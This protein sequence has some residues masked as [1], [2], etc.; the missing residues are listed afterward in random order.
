V[1]DNLNDQ[2][3]ERYDNVLSRYEC[4]RVIAMLP[5]IGQSRG[6][7]GARHLMAVTE[8]D[9]LASDRRL[10]H[11]AR[12]ELADEAIAA[13]RRVLHIEYADSLELNPGIR[14]ALT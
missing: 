10:L 12:R 7:A 5:N 8:I 4:D 3:F 14:L 11:I 6:R 1:K 9:D 2:G 13:P